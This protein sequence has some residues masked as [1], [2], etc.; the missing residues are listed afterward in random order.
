MSKT[1]DRFRSS[2]GLM[3]S[4]DPSAIALWE[5][6]GARM[7]DDKRTWTQRLREAGIKLA[8]PDDG[9]VNRERNTF[10]LSW[11]AQFNNTPDVGDLIAFG[12]PPGGAHYQSWHDVWRGRKDAYAREQMG[13]LK[14]Q[15]ESS[16]RGYRICRVT[17]VDD[18][19]GIL[20]RR[21]TYS[22]EDTGT[23]VPP[24]APNCGLVGR[25]LRWASA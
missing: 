21:V 22:Y 15:P 10:T 2:D 14:D 8:H 17:E 3:E 11:Y 9:W 25:V 24:R 16:A 6:I 13:R 19:G 4:A 1:T 5:S 12:T 18:R 7:E 20:G 23:R